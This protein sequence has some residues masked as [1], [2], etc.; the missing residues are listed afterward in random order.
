MND[1]DVDRAGS[2]MALYEIRAKLKDQDNRSLHKLREKIMAL[3]QQRQSQESNAKEVTDSS[4]QPQS[5]RARYI[6]PK[7]S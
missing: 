4:T 2:L 6:F 7:S 5:G 3:Q 1:D